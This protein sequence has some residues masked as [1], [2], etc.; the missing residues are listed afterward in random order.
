MNV[1][2]YHI[3]TLKNDVRT[4]EKILQNLH[5]VLNKCNVNRI[6]DFL[7]TLSV[8]GFLF[9]SYRKENCLKNKL[10]SLHP[11]MRS[12][13]PE[14]MLSSHKAAENQSDMMTMKQKYDSLGRDTTMCGDP[15]FCF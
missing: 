7:G 5:Y 4:L 3:K 13:R 14:L 8:S 6:I 12:W 15:H 2:I 9:F 1:E 11:I 10:V